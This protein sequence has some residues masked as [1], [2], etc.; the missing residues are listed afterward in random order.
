MTN[1]SGGRKGGRKS[2]SRMMTVMLKKKPPLKFSVFDILG[3]RTFRS[4]HTV[5][6]SLPEQAEKDIT[7]AYFCFVG[8]AGA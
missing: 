5:T 7:M 6:S 4:I 3:N 1:T 8:G 2:K